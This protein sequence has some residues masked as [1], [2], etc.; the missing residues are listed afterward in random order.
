MV[1]VYPGPVGIEQASDVLRGQHA[2][3]NQL[4]QRI[5]LVEVIEAPVD[6][7]LGRADP[8]G[9]I[10]A[11]ATVIDLNRGRLSYHRRDPARLQMADTM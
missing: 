4:A 2:D 10:A 1:D 7:V 3:D 5:L 6:G 8:E 11:P 9:V